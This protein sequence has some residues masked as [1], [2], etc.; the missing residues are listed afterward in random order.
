MRLR[1]GVAVAVA[2]SYSSY[3][4]PG[5]RTS[6]CCRC[7]PKKKKKNIFYSFLPL[8]FKVTTAKEIFNKVSCLGLTIHESDGN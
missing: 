3:L 8:G 2:S 1:S 7:G 6:I 4:T 5:L